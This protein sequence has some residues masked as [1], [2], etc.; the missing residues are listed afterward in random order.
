MNLKKTAFPSPSNTHNRIPLS[1]AY[2]A[3]TLWPSIHLHGVCYWEQRWVCVWASMN[4]KPSVHKQKT[5]QRAFVVVTAFRWRDRLLWQRRQMRL[6]VHP[7]TLTPQKISL[8]LFI[9]INISFER[10]AVLESNNSPLAQHKTAHIRLAQLGLIQVLSISRASTWETWIYQP[11]LKLMGHRLFSSRCRQTVP[12][13][14]YQTG[15]GTNVAGIGAHIIWIGGQ[16][17]L[18]ARVV[19]T[20][21]RRRGN[22]KTACF[23]EG[24]MG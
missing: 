17:K 5:A 16:G 19:K 6:L 1:I 18:F 12:D 14:Q 13:E 21:F 2:S 20:S 11:D 8:A 3:K 23:E 24:N 9:L 4:D 10:W 15:N 7:A 22:K